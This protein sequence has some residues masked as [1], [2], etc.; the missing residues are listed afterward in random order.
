MVGLM[1]MDALE[2]LLL[3]WPENDHHGTDPNYRGSLAGKAANA[4]ISA[5]IIV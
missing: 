3:G 4:R 5:R 1:P 2:E